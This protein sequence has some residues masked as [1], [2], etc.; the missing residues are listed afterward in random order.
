VGLFMQGL[1]PPDKG[2]SENAE[3]RAYLIAKLLWDPATNVSRIIDEFH[4]AFYGAAAQPMRDYH[5][6]LHRQVRPPP[7]GRGHHFWVYAGPAA[8]HLSSDFLERARR[9]LSRA[10]AAAGGDAVRRRV[11][12]ARLTLDYVALWRLLPLSVQGGH[13]QLPDSP[14]VKARWSDFLTRAR[15]LGITSLRYGADLKH[16]EVDLPAR[17]R[18]YGIVTLEN[19]SIRAHVAPELSGRVIQL[20]DKATGLDALRRIDPGERGYPDFG[21]INVAVYPDY[22]SRAWET[23]WRLDASPRSGEMLLSGLCPN[24]IRLRR[25]IALKGDTLRTATIIENPTGQPVHLAVQSR[26]DFSPGSM[27]DPRVAVAFHSLDGRRVDK[28]L[29]D[30]DREPYGGQSLAGPGLPDGEWRAFHRAGGLTLTNRFRKEQVSRCYAGW[31]ARG[32][33]RINLNLWTQRRTLHP[34]ETIS[35]DADYSLA[36]YAEQA[37]LPQE[38]RQKPGPP[39]HRVASLPE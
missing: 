36:G 25:T 14:D 7:G 30:P 16:D 11:Q 29:Y 20:I 28:T 32:D 35:L 26:I 21:G 37:D 4:S 12:R 5:D 8:S 1:T 3:L 24:G 9:L 27:D 34:G 6:L 13:Y 17:L 31:S 10:E 33:N 39:R 19:S 38:L 18:P 22:D 15:G 2:W 23:Q